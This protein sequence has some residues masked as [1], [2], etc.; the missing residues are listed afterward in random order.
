[1]LSEDVTDA[2]P[3]K[4]GTTMVT[5]EWIF[6]QRT[7]SPFG[8]QRAKDFGSLRPQWTDT[9]FASLSK[10]PNVR[11][12]LEAQIKHT[13]R[14]DFLNSCACIEHRREEG[15]ITTA[16]SGSSVYC[17]QH[18][19]NLIEFEVIDRTGTRSLERHC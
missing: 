14:D 19:L 4:A 12:G 15:I 1:V 17:G 2:E 8:Q 3:G 9:F 18:R 6:G 11:R 5:E 10:Q 7:A 13:H 16:I